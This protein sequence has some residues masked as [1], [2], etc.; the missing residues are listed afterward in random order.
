VTSIRAS[1]FALQA[2]ALK[3]SLA[4]SLRQPDLTGMA[5]T[6]ISGSG[7]ILTKRLGAKRWRGGVVFRL[8]NFESE[9]DTL[10]W[11]QTVNCPRVAR[12]VRSVGVKA[13]ADLPAAAKDRLKPNAFKD[14]PK[15]VAK[16][17]GNAEPQLGTLAL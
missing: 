12:S 17:P 3:D 10:E 8:Q 1:E 16:P 5:M 2:N 7:R 15:K 9:W 13:S 11:G 6:S 14:S 4:G